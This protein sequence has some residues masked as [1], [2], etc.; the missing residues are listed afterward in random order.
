M[1]LRT[2]CTDLGGNPNVWNVNANDGDRWLDN[3]DAKPSNRWNGNNKFVFRTR[4]S[5]LFRTLQRAVFLVRIREA[6]LP[7]AKHLADFLEIE[8]DRFVL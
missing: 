3:N 6:F 5:F 8:C 7:P 2:F 4:N 1:A